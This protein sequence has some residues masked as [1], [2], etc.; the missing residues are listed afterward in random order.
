MKLVATVI[1]LSKVI[2]SPNIIA[3]YCRLDVH[4][5]TAFFFFFK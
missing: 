3:T 1:F 2:T 5:V 4:N